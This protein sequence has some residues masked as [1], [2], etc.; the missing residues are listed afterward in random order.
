M[1]LI[2][3]VTI[4]LKIFCSNRDI[5]SSRT[6]NIRAILWSRVIPK[7]DGSVRL[8]SAVLDS[9]KKLIWIFMN[10]SILGTNHMWVRFEISP[11]SRWFLS[12]AL[13]RG[14][15]RSTILSARKLEGMFSLPRRVTYP[16]NLILQTHRRRH[17]G[18]KP[19]PCELCG[20]WFAQK[21]NVRAHMVIHGGTK[22]YLC[23]LQDCGKNSDK[24]FS[25]LGNLKVCFIIS[26]R[27]F[28][29]RSS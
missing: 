23:R 11:D 25:Q 17:T 18:E 9:C 15:M 21:G 10:E 26:A 16:T 12:I 19:Y 3:I 22:P 7:N 29:S 1:V 14:R 24:T 20:K 13:P 5:S 27:A 2:S 8:G 4:F 6:R 28:C